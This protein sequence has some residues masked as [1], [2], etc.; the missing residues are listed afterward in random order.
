MSDTSIGYRAA[1]IL[2]DGVIATGSDTDMGQAVQAAINALGDIGAVTATYN[3]ET[4]TVALDASD[5]T[6]GALTLIAWLVNQLAGARG[7]SPELAVA[8]AR[9]FLSS[10]D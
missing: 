6:G 7:I 5:L 8:E 2:L 1:E 10:L 4:D 3:D 9:E